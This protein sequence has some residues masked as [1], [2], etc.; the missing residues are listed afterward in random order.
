MNAFSPSFRLT[1]K[2]KDQ[3]ELSKESRFTLAYGGSRSGT[4]FG[5]CYLTG[6]RAGTRNQ[7]FAKTLWHAVSPAASAFGRI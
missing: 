3:R 2:Q 1:A 6:L 5:F 4:T 7:C